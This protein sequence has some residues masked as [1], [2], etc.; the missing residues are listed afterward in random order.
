MK[1]NL[2]ASATATTLGLLAG[3]FIFTDMGCGGGGG[4]SAPK[5]ETDFCIEKAEAECKTLLS[6]CQFTEAT[7]VTARTA[8]CN[9]V[10]A[11]SQRSTVRAFTEE[12]ISACTGA[13][14]SILSKDAISPADWQK[15]TDACNR[16]WAASRPKGELCTSSYDCEEGLFCDSVKGRCATEIKKKAMEFCADPGSVC[17]AG[18]YCEKLD[19]TTFQC[20]ARAGSGQACGAQPDGMK[21]PLCVDSLRCVAGKCEAKVAPGMSCTTNGDCDTGLCDPF[22][23]KCRT[24]IRFAADSPGCNAYLGVS[25]G[26][27]SGDASTD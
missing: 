13:I 6:K 18:E 26:A 3:V 24:E 10:L 25:Q 27:P 16:V 1:R 14:K 19:A 7:C 17:V 8:A 4:S 12:N 2:I 9:N 11:P 20:V 21:N 22:A 5:T 15:L 23:M